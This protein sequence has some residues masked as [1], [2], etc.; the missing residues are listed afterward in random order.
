MIHPLR[1][2]YDKLLLAAA[3]VALGISIGWVHRQRSGLRSVGIESVG[4][5]S[6]MVAYKPA[7]QKATMTSAPAWTMPRPQSRGE[8]WL[9][10]VFTPPLIHYVAATRAF[11]L[12][13][14][15][16]ARGI[17]GD[18]S[19][20]CRLLA[21]KPEAYRLQ[22]AGY[23]GAPDDYLAVFTTPR[24]TG[25][26]LARPGHRFADL[27]LTFGNFEVRKVLVAEAEFGP[28]YEVAALAMLLDEQSG[29]EVV[30]DSRKQRLADRAV[31]VFQ[32]PD[33]AD[34][35][36]ELREGDTFAEAGSVCRIERIQLEPAE[37]LVS[38]TAPGM[39]AAE[40]IV[41]RP[42]AQ[43]TTTTSRLEAGSGIGGGRVASNI[44]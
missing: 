39:P 26:I 38:R 5:N 19:P 10:E 30:L 43:T 4:S 2:H 29:R 27:E 1:T 35:R 42:T 12:A 17:A 14:T 9:Y 31:A 33:E 15:E 40:L 13:P 25:T 22:L 3:I 44:P 8:G 7:L 21:V 20:A 41:L 18:R 37:V 6:A 28:V 23:F 11:A 16:P 34:G 24:S 36:R 32:L